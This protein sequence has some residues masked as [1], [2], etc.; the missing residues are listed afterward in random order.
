MPSA[1]W[2]VPIDGTTARKLEFDAN[3]VVPFAQ[4]KIQ[5]HPDGHQLAFVSGHHRSMEVWAL[6]N[7]LPALK[8]SR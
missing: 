6:E 1:L 7:F 4:V 8:A 2:L 3:R 5:L